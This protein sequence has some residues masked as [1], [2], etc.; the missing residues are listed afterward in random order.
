VGK[1]GWL[2]LTFA[3]LLTFLFPGETPAEQRRNAGWSLPS[4]QPSQPKRK[5]G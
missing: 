4:P 3:L 1:A 2:I 5:A